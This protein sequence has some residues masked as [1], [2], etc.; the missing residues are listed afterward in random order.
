MATPPT[1]THVVFETTVGDFTVELYYEHAP[2]TCFNLAELA[3]RGYYNNTI[4]H[5]IIKVCFALYVL[6]VFFAARRPLT[7]AWQ[8]FM[9]QGGDPTGTGRG[10][11]SVYGGKFNDEISKELKHTGAGVVSMANA[12]PNTNGSQ[13]FVTL[14]PTPWLDGKHTI[15]GRISSGMRVIQRMGLVPTGANDRNMDEDEPAAGLDGDDKLSSR[16]PENQASARQGEGEGEGGETH[17]VHPPQQDLEVLK[18]DLDP[19][20]ARPLSSGAEDPAG[21]GGARQLAWVQRAPPRPAFPNIFEFIPMP[22]STGSPALAETRPPTAVNDDDNVVAIS[23]SPALPNEAE[24]PAAEPASPRSRRLELLTHLERQWLEDT[25]AL[26]DA[27]EAPTDLPEFGWHHVFQLGP[28]LAYTT[29]LLR[30]DVSPR[31]LVLDENV[32]ATKEA[33]SSTMAVVLIAA[34]L[35]FNRSTEE[36]VLRQATPPQQKKP[37]VRKRRR[38]KT[39]GESTAARASSRL[40]SVLQAP[41]RRLVIR[42]FRRRSSSR[43]R[44]VVVRPQRRQSSVE[45]SII[46]SSPVAET[47]AA[48]LS[49]ALALAHRSLLSALSTSIVTPSFLPPPNAVS[50][51]SSRKALGRSK[52]A[53]KIGDLGAIALFHALRVNTTLRSV[54]LENAGISDASMPALAAMLRHNTTLTSLSLRANGVGPLGVAALCDALDDMPDASLLSLDLAHNRMTDAGLE[55]LRVAL[56]NNETLVWLDVSWNQL[57][58]RAVLALLESLRENFVLR[59]LAVHGRDLDDDAFCLNIES[60]YALALAASLRQANP[61]LA[62]I[63]LTSEAATLPIDKLKDSRWLPLAGKQLVEVDALVIAGLLPLNDRLLR[64]DLSNNPGIER[65]AVLELLKSM[66]YCKTLRHVN[67][68]NTGLYEEVAE[69]VGELVAANDTLETIVMHETELHVQQLR[70]HEPV[71]T[72]SLQVATSHFLDRWILTRCLALNRVTQELNALRLPEPT[73]DALSGRVTPVSIN[74]SG[75]ALALYEVTFLAKKVFHHLHVAR[76]A[77]NGCTIDSVGGVALA[78][79][80]RN[81][82]S[83]ETLELENNALGAS[84]GRAMAECVQFNASLTFLNLSWNRLGNDGVA[85]LASALPRNVRLLRLDLRGNEL[86]TAGIQAISAGLRGNAC[87]QELYLRWNTI[88][89]AGAEALAQALA[90][91]QSLRVLDVEHHTMGPRGALAF[92]TM[93]RKNRHLRELNMKGDDSISDGD[94]HGIGA[95]A[96]QAIAGALT[97]SN[98]ALA[99]LSIGQNQVGRDGIAAFAQLVKVNTTLRVLD[100]SLSPMDGKLAERFF[101]CLSMNCTLRKLSLAHNHISNDGM[102][103]CLRALERNKTL[104]DLNLAHNGITEEPLALFAAKLRQRLDASAL[105]TS[106]AVAAARAAK[107]A[108]AAPAAAAVSTTPATTSASTKAPPQAPTAALKWVCLI[109]NTMTEGT[110]RVFRSLAPSITVE[111]EAELHRGPTAT[112]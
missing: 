105:A 71:D 82:S 3:R 59:G 95:D 78:D 23:V 33:M 54:A 62:S 10:G 40:V 26:E 41:L 108:P 18:L 8:D 91:N 2:R 11:E 98:R 55:L 80:L 47:L 106:V 20:H 39:S 83:V 36:F 25:R 102:A 43:P 7:R 67:L 64:L 112:S 14:A 56:E 97:E 89:P 42:G 50:I 79:A 68:A 44:Y 6:C 13:F 110:R 88:C 74:V 99:T 30:R 24:T 63:A 46:R 111:L 21:I 70:G 84:G 58:T 92:A 100:L 48:L 73:R 15:F 107:R 109:G 51:S 76:L 28:A 60:K 57:S 52:P 31:F 85:G 49:R 38:K 65:W 66:R 32:D 69:L 16:E 86:S 75:R 93:L 35:A 61:S 87:L 77:M 53:T 4:F 37:V 90:G 27:Y 19:E 104:E 72:L 12:G 9:I 45:R 96:A 5:R 101:E 34:G 1:P 29:L 17:D 103:A 81:H 22:E 94:A